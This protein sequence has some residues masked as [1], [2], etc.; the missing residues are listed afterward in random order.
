[1]WSVC[2]WC[3][4]QLTHSYCVTGA[5]SALMLVGGFG[6]GAVMRMSWQQWHCHLRSGE[7][8]NILFHCPCAKIVIQL[9]TENCWHLS[10]MLIWQVSVSVI[11]QTMSHLRQQI[12]YCLFDSCLVTI[13]IF[14]QQ[15]WTLSCISYTKTILPFLSR[16]KVFSYKWSISKR[17]MLIVYIRN[18]AKK[19]I[20]ISLIK[21]CIL[22]H[23]VLAVTNCLYSF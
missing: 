6:S 21:S 13:I 20:V 16:F 23:F 18:N 3:S 11:K 5:V 12:S 8:Y 17:N 14:M 19:L 22:T 15:T 10:C 7:S 2:V 4:Q 9:V 1:M